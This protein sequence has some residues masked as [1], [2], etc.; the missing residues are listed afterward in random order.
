MVIAGANGIFTFEMQTGAPQQAAA[1]A[2]SCFHMI[3]IYVLARALDQL[4]R[5]QESLG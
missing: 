3:T 2:V 4:L 5:N 1:A